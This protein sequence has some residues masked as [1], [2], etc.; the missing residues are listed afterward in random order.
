MSVSEDRK[1]TKEKIVEILDNAVGKTLGEVDSVGAKLFD[2]VKGY[3]KVTG[4]AGDVI[5]QSVLGYAPNREQGCDIE[6]DGILVEVK[7]TGV[8][9]KK[10]DRK[11]VIN[12]SGAAYNLYLRAKEGLTITGVTVNPPIQMDFESSHFW[13][14]TARMLIVMYE[15]KS[16]ITVSPSGYAKFPIVDYFYNTF[17]E[18]EQSKLKKDWEIV[19]DYLKNHYATH[20]IDTDRKEKLVGFTRILRPDLLLI[21][22]APGYTKIKSP[23]RGNV[24]FTTPRYRLKK[25]FVDYIVRG[26]FDKSR[27]KYE[28]E[29]KEPFS[30]FEELDRR[31]REITQKYKGKSFEELK[32]ELGITTSMA[33]KD[34]AAKAVLKMFGADCKKLNQI[35]DFLKAGIEARTITLDV[36]GR[37][38]EDMKFHLIDFDE[39]TDRKIKFEESDIFTFFIEHSLLCPIFTEYDPKDKSKTIFEGFKRFSFDDEFIEKEVGRMWKD[40]RKMIHDKTL[41]WEYKYKNGEPIINKTGSYRGAPNLP[42]RSEYTV[43]FRGSNSD[44][45]NEKRTEEVNGIKMLPQYFW[46]KGDFIAQKLKTLDYL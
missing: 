32:N 39:W 7:T 38:T 46:I 10:Q 36:N 22:L 45:S 21:D 11:R 33:T 24:S 37:Y 13:E 25:T 1:Y 12:K 17:S 6:I 3:K 2:K 16:I 31:C 35:S 41:V 5:E 23:K 44:S 8:R 18:S 26:H 20:S 19:R 9:V 42:K 27:S 14:K 40:S 15:Y 43:F 29:L 28:V 30:S 34:F 4:I